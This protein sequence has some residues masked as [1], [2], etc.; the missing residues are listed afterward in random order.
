MQPIAFPTC[1]LA[2]HGI[3]MEGAWFCLQH[4]FAIHLDGLGIE[5]LYHLQP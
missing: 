3:T 5:V 2:I 1:C 4:G